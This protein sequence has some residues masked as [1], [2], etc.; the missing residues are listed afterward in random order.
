MRKISLMGVSLCQ[1]DGDKLMFLTTDE[2]SGV[3]QTGRQCIKNIHNIEPVYSPE[4]LTSGN[5]MTEFKK[6]STCCAP[7]ACLH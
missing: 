5:K 2:D 3:P 6:K 7:F 4:P 1:Y